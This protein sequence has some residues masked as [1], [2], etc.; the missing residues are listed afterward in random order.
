MGTVVDLTGPSCWEKLNCQGSMNYLCF[1]SA[2]LEYLMNIAPTVSFFL[3][4]Q[5][6]RPKVPRAVQS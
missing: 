1:P 2:Y 4:L 3:N 5:K 6:P